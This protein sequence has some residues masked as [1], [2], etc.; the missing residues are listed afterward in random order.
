MPLYTF[1]CDKCGHTFECART[2]AERDNHIS[3]RACHCDARR[4]PDTPAF[5]IEGYA[6]ANGYSGGQKDR[7]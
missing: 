1:H 7:K 3:C 2:I 5:K 6:E 4:L